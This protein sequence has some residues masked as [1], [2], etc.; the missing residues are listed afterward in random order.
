MG[1]L[2]LS[3]MK[4]TGFIVFILVTVTIFSFKTK[5]VEVNEW[6]IQTNLSDVLFTLGEPF[7]LHYIQHK[8]AELV[9]KGKEIIF[10]GRTTNARNKKTKRQSKYFVCT[11]C[12]NTKIEDPSLFLPEPEPRLAFAIQNNLPFL[13]GTTFKGIVNRETWYNDD[14]YKKYGK[15]VESSRDTLINA[16]QLCATEC[17]QGRKFEKWEIE[18]VLHYFWSLDYSLGELGLNEKEYE[19]LNKAIKEKRK[20]A[21]LIKLLKS[22]YAQKSPALFGDAPYDKKKGYENITGNATHGAW[23]YEKSCMFCHDEKRLSNLN[24]DYEKA[25]FKLLTKNLTLH[26]EKSV[27][28]AIRYGTK[29][30]PGKRPYMPHYTISRMSNQQTEDLVAFIKK[31]SGE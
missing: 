15:A 23:I 19:L 11:D 4:K 16:I 24:L 8:N 13:Q 22:K 7:P 30:V 14:Y 3:L 5:N 2:T 1:L 17:S 18:A 9:K 21:S 10:Y 27:Y 12:H 25:T 6:N 26:N 31:Q 28:Q 20:D 29:P